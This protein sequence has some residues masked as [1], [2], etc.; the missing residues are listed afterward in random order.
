MPTHK[1]EEFFKAFYTWAEACQ[2][3]LPTDDEEQKRWRKEFSSH[4][5]FIE[6]AIHK[7]C[8]LDRLIYARESNWA[9]HVFSGLAGI[10]ARRRLPFGRVF[11]NPRIGTGQSLSS[12]YAN[13]RKS[14]DSDQSH[15]QC[16]NVLKH[17]DKSHA[18]FRGLV[19]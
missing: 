11:G 4:W 16:E 2:T 15:P 9:N 14:N 1:A 7:S 17:G 8:L 3:E 12:A 10:L 18:V 19:L 13:I 6:L 5:S